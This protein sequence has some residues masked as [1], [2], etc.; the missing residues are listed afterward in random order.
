MPSKKSV[1]L[2]NCVTKPWLFQLQTDRGSRAAGYHTLRSKGHQTPEVFLPMWYFLRYH[3]IK[4]GLVHEKVSK[5]KLKVETCSSLAKNHE[6]RLS[7]ALL[8]SL[9]KISLEFQRAYGAHFWKPGLQYNT[10]QQICVQ[11]TL[12]L[13]QGQPLT[14]QSMPEWRLWA[15]LMVGCITYGH[16][17]S[18]PGTQ[19]AG[20]WL[21]IQHI[22]NT[23]D[24]FVAHSVSPWL[25]IY[26][27]DSI[28]LSNFCVW[29][30]TYRRWD[31]RRL[32]W[33]QWSQTSLSW[34]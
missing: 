24:H 9:K 23:S 19:K 22:D 34:V 7:K 28:L 1:G 5:W 10:T 8:L 16:T 13:W 33:P 12:T 25:L 27:I 4:I 14:Y 20:D 31:G 11:R 32:S 2:C 3:S 17:L 30:R 26:T 15:V 29:R 18:F 21:L 6:A